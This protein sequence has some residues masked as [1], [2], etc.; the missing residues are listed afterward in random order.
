MFYN[1]MWTLVQPSGGGT[2]P[3]QQPVVTVLGPFSTAVK[4]A[5]A[6][7]V[8]FAVQPTAPT[9]GTNF[10]HIAVATVEID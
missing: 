1:V 5:A 4:A 2:A 8:L 7:T 6:K 10:M 9:G 3:N